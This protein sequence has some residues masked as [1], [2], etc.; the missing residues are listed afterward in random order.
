[1]LRRRVQSR[2]AFRT[3]QSAAVAVEK[4]RNGSRVLEL[5]DPS[6][7]LVK[8]RSCPTLSGFLTCN[9]MRNTPKQVPDGTRFAVTNTELIF[10]LVPAYFAFTTFMVGLL[11][12]GRILLTFKFRMPTLE[13][14]RRGLG[15]EVNG[16]NSCL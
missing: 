16:P 15:V 6:K 14:M 12:L 4:G 11:F 2:L 8:R 3:A 7:S 13:A 9:G 5:S 10:I 1:M